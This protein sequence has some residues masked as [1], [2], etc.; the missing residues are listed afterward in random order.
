MAALSVSIC[1][2]LLAPELRR[3]ARAEANRRAS[4]RMLAVANALEGLA[5]AEAARLAGML[6]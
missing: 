6:G 3:L 5:R 2:V 1:S 4:L